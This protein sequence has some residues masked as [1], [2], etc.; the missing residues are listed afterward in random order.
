MMEPDSFGGLVARIDRAERDIEL[1]NTYRHELRTEVIAVKTS[2]AVITAGQV[3]I[4]EDMSELK[5]QMKWVLRGLVT[6]TITFTGL[7][8]TIIV[9]VFSHG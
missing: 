6:A 4:K 2:N 3:E 1:G 9:A 5:D 7:I 8:I